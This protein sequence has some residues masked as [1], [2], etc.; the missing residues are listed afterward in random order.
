MRKMKTQIY[1]ARRL[2]AFTLVEL[3]VVMAVI[4]VLA[5]MLFPAAGAIKKKAAIGKARTELKLAAMAIEK[6]KGNLSHYPPD[7]P[8]NPAI[9]QLY[10][11]LVGT[12]RVNN[13]T[14]YQVESGASGIRTSD[15]PGF[16][17][18]GNKV[19][20][21]VNVS[22]GSGDEVRTARNCL[23]GLKPSNYLEV[24]SGGG[25]GTVLGITAK[26]PFMLSDANGNAINP[27]C[28]IS[29]G[30]TNNNTSYDLWVDILVGGK[31]N[32]ISNWSEKA[33]VVAY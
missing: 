21:F 3:L 7:N 25:Q 2:S 1:M 17:G 6:Y 32:R 26:G 19:T 9:N 4:A 28:Y 8:A 22:D 24:Q 23:V 10:Y 16:Y 20:G 13:G 18:L 12:K 29:T 14:E 27:I 33:D 5:A 15:F 31:T 30:P 11:E